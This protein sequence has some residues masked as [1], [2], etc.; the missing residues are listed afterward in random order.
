MVS[1]SSKRMEILCEVAFSKLAATT[2]VPLFKAR[3]VGERGLERVCDASSA[4][5]SKCDDIRSNCYTNFAPH[6]AD[7]K[8]L[9]L[10]YGLIDNAEGSRH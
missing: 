4:S 6:S 3:V 8:I 9:P 7:L 1:D 5:R 2:G 10:N